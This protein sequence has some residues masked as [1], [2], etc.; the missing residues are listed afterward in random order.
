MKTIDITLDAETTGLL[1]DES[2]DYSAS[3]YK[4][5]DSFSVH[6]IVVEVHDTGEL[7]AFYDGPEYVFDGRAYEESDDKYTYLLEDY[8]PITYTR[9]P[10]SYFPKWV[11]KN[12]IYKVVA[13]NGINYDWL[14]FK[15]YFGMDYEINPDTW[16]GKQVRFEDTLV[17]AKTLNPDRF[18]GA[19]LENLAKMAKKAQKYQF[20]KD[21]PQADR[22]KT[23]AADMLYYNI[24][25]VKSNTDV[26]RYLEWEK[27]DWDWEDAI[28]LEK[29][30]AEIIT[31]Q[32]HRGFDFNKDLAESNVREL[33]AMMEERRQ[34]VEP[35]LPPRAA[36][37]KFLKE[38]TP[39]A[40]QQ[41]IKPLVAPKNQFLKN[42]TPSASMVKFAEKLN[43]TLKQE[44][45]DWWLV[46]ENIKEKLPLDTEKPFKVEY[47]LAAHMKNWL[48]KHGGRPNKTF[49]KVK[50]YDKIYELP[51]PVEPIKTEMV[52]TI[53]DTTHIKDWLVGLGWEPSEWKEKDISVKSG[54]AKIK[55]TEEELHE[56]VDRYIEESRRSNFLNH[57]LEHLEATDKNFKIKLW[58]KAS[59]RS[60]RVR[61]N[62]SFTVGQDKE[63]CPGLEQLAEKFP[64]AKDVVEY[65]TYKHRR[66]SI[67]GGGLD[68]EEG[69]EEA[70]R[71]YL[72]N[73]RSDGRIPTPADSCGA[74]TS[75]MKHK[76][77]AN[78]PRVTSLYGK[79]MRGLFGVDKSKY[80]QIGY[81]FSSLEARIEAHYCWIFEKGKREYCNSLLLEKP[82][83]VHTK[84]AEKITEILGKLFERSPA[85]AVKYGCTYGAQAA[86]VAKTIGSDLKT[87]EIVFDAFWEAALPLKKLK[88]AL[89]QY[90]KNQGGKKFIK[91]ID[92]RKIP[93]RAEHAILN[94]LFQSAGVICAKKTMVLHDKL[95]KKEGYAVDFFKEDWKNI[96]YCQQL[97]AYHDECQLEESK[98]NF[99]FKWFEDEDEANDFVKEQCKVWSEPFKV[100]DKYY[101]G[102]SR[103]AELISVAVDK[104]TEHFNLNVPLHAGYILGTNWA[105]CH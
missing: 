67:L 56:A 94:S 91:G 84:T 71:G 2:I 62:P 68:W 87:G 43:C 86:K 99:E 69:E 37:K 64:Y 24:F 32:E 96:D 40:Q 1:N 75:R 31:R 78:I 48:K 70:E 61:T 54:P 23:F 65:L 73:L 47:E 22:F 104:T 46:G 34:R 95:L 98:S 25:D 42:R 20:R 74:A 51:M 58:Q 83:D 92:G 88:E 5:K 28:T 93:T 35:L 55:R 29:E 6:C 85:K 89:V 7:I 79:N 15:L 72:A 16:A 21:I 45:I 13:H 10:L 3:P 102:Y 57:R 14:V 17:T 36:T 8:E 27:G 63:M 97:I 9:Y 100:G 44:G 76:V 90:W 39:P 66:N 53:D 49:T 52:A 77:V 12:P 50:V 11:S 30:V 80:V 19:S 4:L 38:Y 82:N 105:E 41:L 81:D 26:Y 18:G 101:V 103:A 59:K 33:D 60:C